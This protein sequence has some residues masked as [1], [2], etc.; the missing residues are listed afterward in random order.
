V[1]ASVRAMLGVWELVI[2]SWRIVCSLGAY[3]M[4]TSEGMRI[5]FPIQ[6]MRFIFSAKVDSLV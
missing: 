3:M 6:S 2:A 4:L 1:P 5:R